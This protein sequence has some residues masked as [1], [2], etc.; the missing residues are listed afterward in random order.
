MKTA[1]ST[2]VFL[3]AGFL[4]SAQEEKLESIDALI[5][6]LGSQKFTV[7]EHAFKTL[8]NRQEAEAALRQAARFSDTETQRRIALILEHYERRPLREL[9]CF[10]KSGRMDEVIQRVADWPEGKYEDELWPMTIGLIG[11]LNMLHRKKKGDPESTNFGETKEW[12]KPPP[13]LKTA[14][15]TES[16]KTKREQMYFVRTH[17]FSLGMKGPFYSDQ[18][19]FSVFFVS[20]HVK[21]ES[22]LPGIILSGKD[23]RISGGRRTSNRIVVSG[24]DVIMSG[25]IGNSLIIARG[26]IVYQGPA[27]DFFNNHVIAGKKVII[28]GPNE[29]NL[30]VENEPNPLGYIRW[31]DS[32]KVKPGEKR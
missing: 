8:I 21:T 15:V 23:I 29:D 13:V 3:A 27:F 32:P 7:R 1:I 12:L 20:G 22:E 6:K 26:N 4:V 19:L 17:D 16:T 2:V 14:R 9:A 24:G 10:I 31:S 28:P 5:K 18:H 30:I 25:S 11:K